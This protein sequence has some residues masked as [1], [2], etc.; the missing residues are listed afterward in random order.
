MNRTI[1]RLTLAIFVLGLSC[2]RNREL[3][4]ELKTEPESV[5]HTKEAVDIV[6]KSENVLTPKSEIQVP[7]TLIEK[8][9]PY[10]FSQE[11]DGQ[12]LREQLEPRIDRSADQLTRTQPRRELG[13]LPSLATDRIP[14]KPFSIETLRVPNQ[15]I[16]LLK[17]KDPKEVIPDQFWLMP[18]ALPQLSKLEPSPGLG[19][20]SN[21]SSGTAELPRLATPLIDR[22]SLEDPTTANSASFIRAP[23]PPV[24][25]IKVPLSASSL[26]D[27]FER[28]DIKKFKDPF[29]IDPLTAT[30]SIRSK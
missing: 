18:L 14:G 25:E 2:S 20:P 4:V 27:P 10:E 15:P 30:Q 13:M 24:H 7:V 1:R 21:S 8:L 9:T 3:K 23:L 28:Q 5:V 26:P 12:S 22:F 16:E 17:P 6:A 29:P 11:I 19:I